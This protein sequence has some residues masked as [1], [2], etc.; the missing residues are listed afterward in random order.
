MVIAIVCQCIPS[1]LNINDIS[2][3]ASYLKVHFVKYDALSMC[4][5]SHGSCRIDDMVACSSDDKHSISKSVRSNI[6]QDQVQGG[7]RMFNVIQQFMVSSFESIAIEEDW[8]A[9]M[10]I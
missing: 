1:P 4:C 2:I 10:C 6:S 8:G 3:A 7:R 9:V 5:Q